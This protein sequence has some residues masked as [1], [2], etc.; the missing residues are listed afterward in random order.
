MSIADIITAN[1]V[2]MLF[3]DRRCRSIRSWIIIFSYFIFK[4]MIEKLFGP[5]NILSHINPSH[6]HILNLIITVPNSKRRMMAK[7]FDIIF[8]LSFYIW[9]EVIIK[10]R[11]RLASELKILPNKN[12]TFVASIIKFI[13]FVIS[14]TPNSNHIHIRKLNGIKHIIK[15]F[16]IESGNKTVRRNIIWAFDKKRNSV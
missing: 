15:L 16:L 1:S 5:I 8:Y 13:A 7:P 11:V 14:A 4:N 10:K 3:A 6:V 12:T 9:K 2:I